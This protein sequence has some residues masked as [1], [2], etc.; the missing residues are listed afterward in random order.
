MHSSGG[1]VFYGRAWRV[2]AAAGCVLAGLVEAVQAAAARWP[3][4]HP[5]LP[6]PPLLLCI[7][8]AAGAF[9]IFQGK[10]DAKFVAEVEGNAERGDTQLAVGGLA[11]PVALAVG[12]AAQWEA[13]ASGG[14]SRTEVVQLVYSD[15]TGPCY[16]TDCRFLGETQVHDA[17]K[18]E[19]GQIYVMRWKDLDGQFANSL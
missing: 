11:A 18:L 2:S 14:C 5:L 17:S 12:C 8:A 6:P 9:V 10:I 15:N 3:C 16:L 1:Y 13:G 19:V 4:H 7:W